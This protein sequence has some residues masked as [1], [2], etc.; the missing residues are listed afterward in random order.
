MH[1][2]DQVSC[3]GVGKPPIAFQLW[4]SKLTKAYLVLAP[5]MNG[6]P[7]LYRLPP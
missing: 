5:K 7:V 3:E 6:L 2:I 1:L 4:H